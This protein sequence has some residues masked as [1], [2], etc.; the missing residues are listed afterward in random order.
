MFYMR[1]VSPF[2]LTVTT[3]ALIAACASSPTAP[4]EPAIVTLAPGQSTQV[5]AL[6]LKFAG[7]TIDTRCPANAF[8]IQVGD[9]YAALEAT[10]FGVTRAFELQVLNP[11]NRS[12]T[13]GSYS[14]ELQEISPYPFGE[15]IKPADYR[16]KLRIARE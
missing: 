3:A 6:S 15:P 7:V 1:Y 14:I 8:C 10:W 11:T 5:G 4:T 16:V 12:T 9:A 13:H 2:V